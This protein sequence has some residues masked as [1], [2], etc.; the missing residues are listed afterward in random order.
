MNER[1]QDPQFKDWTY[2]LVGT[3]GAIIAG[4]LPAWPAE[5]Q[6][7]E[8]SADL[9]LP[10]A[11]LGWQPPSVRATYTRLPDGSRLLLG[12]SLA[13]L[14]AFRGR[15]TAALITAATL[16]LILA[17][18]AGIS[19]SRRSVARIEAIN[20]TSRQIMGSGLGERIPLRG[21]RDEWDGLAANLNSMRD[22]IQELAEW[23]R[24]V[25]DNIAHDLR[26]PLT[27]LRGRLEKAC[28][29]EPN[30]L[31]Y[32]ELV[33]DALGELDEI[34]KTCSSLLRISQIENRDR[35]AA[36]GQINLTEIAREVVDLFDPTA[37]E[38]KIRLQFW[39]SEPQ[40]VCGD[41]DLLFDAISN[42]VDNAIKQGGRRGEVRIAADRRSEGPVLSIADRGPG[43]PAE[44]RR[45]VMKR[46]YRL[47]GSRNSP[48]N[49]LGLSLVAAVA[50]L[51]D[52]EIIMADN[53]PGL[54]VE[55]H[56]PAPHARTP[57][58]LDHSRESSAS[59]PLLKRPR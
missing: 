27:R 7:A 43:I 26:T 24:Q 28:S 45:K 29:Q 38:Q 56:F 37:E 58:D 40:F 15:I 30:L 41:R 25:S 8:G 18:A 17:A 57:S 21:T 47:E 51:H 44:E 13:E 10:D 14:D 49:G 11:P 39:G 34:L 59:L 1:A 50:D 23:N 32:R 42:L 3:S 31:G 35:T 19:T 52:V 33:A 36:F 53:A 22:R 55:L 16:F 9:S 54:S 6:D 46:F 2:L 5:L 48:G 12:R 4:N 20:T